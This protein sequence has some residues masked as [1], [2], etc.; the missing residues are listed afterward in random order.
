MMDILKPF[1]SVILKWGGIA[2]G[3][4]LIIF[5]IRQS[6]TQAEQRK[7]AMDTLAEVRTRDKIANDIANSSDSKLNKLYQKWER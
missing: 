5:K 7:E 1:F 4:L 3:M 6:G 2:S